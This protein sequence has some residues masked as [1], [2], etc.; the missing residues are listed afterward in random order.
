[1]YEV[2]VFAAPPDDLLAFST[3]LSSSSLWADLSASI[4]SMDN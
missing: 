3:S 1:M 2:S 4:A